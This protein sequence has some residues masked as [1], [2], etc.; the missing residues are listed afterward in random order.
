MLATE[1]LDQRLGFLDIGLNLRPM[2]EVIR[3][4]GIDFTKRN[5]GKLLANLFGRQPL[6]LVDH[7]DVLYP[8]AMTRDTRSAAADAGSP[9]D[10][11]IGRLRFHGLLPVCFLS[12]Y[13]RG[14]LECQFH[15]V[16]TMDRSSA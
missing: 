4:S 9:S 16:S 3:Q 11:W 12:L 1:R 15:A 7:G 2:I 5:A 13:P 6:M 14:C 10:M 8:D